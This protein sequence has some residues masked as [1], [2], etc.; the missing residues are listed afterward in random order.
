MKFIFQ[1]YNL[2]GIAGLISL[3]LSFLFAKKSISIHLSDT[4]YV[5]ASGTI[6]Q[7]FTALL[8]FFFVVYRLTGHF[9]FSDWFSWVHITITLLAMIVIAIL[10]FLAETLN[11]AKPS[12][13][14][15]KKWTNI[16]SFDKVSKTIVIASL[17]LMIAQ[18]IYIANIA[19]GFI[20][21]FS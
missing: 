3:V 15:L 8:F 20:K 4:Y 2:L 10:P 17:G 14:G 12:Y 6:F 21:R 1:P 16:D 11:N 9:L 7:V 5:I 13:T 18:L 19:G